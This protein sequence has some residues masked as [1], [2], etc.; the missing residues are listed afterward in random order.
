METLIKSEFPACLPQ[1][2]DTRMC[3]PKINNQAV[4]QACL[5]LSAG[6]TGLLEQT[7]H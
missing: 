6:Q 1:A 4:T 2:G 3:R 7:G 5:S